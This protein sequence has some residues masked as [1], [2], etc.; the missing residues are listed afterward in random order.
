MR[1]AIAWL[2]AL[3]GAAVAAADEC[4]CVDASIELGVDS[5]VQRYRLTDDVLGSDP[6]E[7]LDDIFGM[8]S[9]RDSTEVFN[10]LRAQG[11]LEFRTAGPVNQLRARLRG[12]AGTELHRAAADIDYRRGAYGDR[13]RF[14]LSADF[15]LRAFGLRTAHTT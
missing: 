10:E 1:P 14:D 8:R 4:D 11:S 2:L 7:S 13:S 9:L 15:D 6:N 3:V 12:S 5:F